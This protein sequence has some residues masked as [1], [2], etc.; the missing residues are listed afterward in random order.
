MQKKNL[1]ICYTEFSSPDELTN[2]DKRLLEEAI[3]IG[4]SAYAPY[5]HYHV[6]ASVLLSDGQMVHGNNQE[7]MAFPSG[8]CAER[9]ALFA[10]SANHPGVPVVAI[11]IAA[12]SREF[13]VVEPVTP[14]GA[15]R[16]AMIEYENLQTNP[17]RLILGCESGK[18]IIV[19]SVGDLLPLSFKEEKLKRQ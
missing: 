4:K 8:L 16:Q 15:C 6:G 19:E 3:T 7:N 9:V 1:V 2:D 18:T 5:S 14:C 11:A 17:I 12:A 13:P 10:A